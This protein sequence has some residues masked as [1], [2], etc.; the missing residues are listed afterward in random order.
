MKEFENNIVISF[1]LNGET[2]RQRIDADRVKCEQHKREWSFVF[3]HRGLRFRVVGD[4]DS[5]GDLRTDGPIDKTG[6][7]ARFFVETPV[8][9]YRRIDDVDIIA[10]DVPMQSGRMYITVQIDYEYEKFDKKIPVA[11]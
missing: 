11:V 9:G 3:Y 2:I 4:I 10:T 5:D 8:A 7:M 1:R 6:R